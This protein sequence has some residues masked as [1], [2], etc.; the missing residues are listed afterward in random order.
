MSGLGP[1]EIAALFLAACRAELDAPK[2]GNVH[3]HADGHGMTVADFL[4]SA[5]AAAPCLAKPGLSVGARSLAAVEATRAACGQ[6]TNLGIVLLCA[7]LAVAAQCSGELQPNLANVL[8]RLDRSDAAFAYRAIRLASPGG[9]G[10]SERHDVADEP[11]ITLLKAMREAAERDRIAQQYATRFADL[12]AIG[13][14]R[15]EACRAAGWAEPWA[16][17]ASYLAL[18]SAFPDTHVL[19]KHGL[20]T[21]QRVQAQGESLDRLLRRKASPEGALERLL[22]VDRDLKGQGINPGTTAD[23]TVASH[24][25]SGLMAAMN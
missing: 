23:L 12:F 20:Q 1:E 15:L 24:F 9:L 3:V 16:V 13:V 17:V 18:L 19:R 2:P 8:E 22:A 21:A 25:A 5:E 7:P 11:R 6:N 4:I 10:R 14:A